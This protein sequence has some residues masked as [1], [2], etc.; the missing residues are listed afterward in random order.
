[1]Q[2][3]AAFT[4]ELTHDYQDQNLVW[5][6]DLGARHIYDVDAEGNWY[7]IGEFYDNI[8]F[9]N[10]TLVP[11]RAPDIFVAKL[12]HNGDWA[13][14]KA[15][16]GGNR[17]GGEARAL[18]VFDDGSVY[19]TGTFR[20]NITLGSIKLSTMS[21]SCSSC[22]SAEANAHDVFVAKLNENGEW[23]WATSGGGTAT[24]QPYAM[25]LTSQGEAVI[26]GQT[27]AGH[28]WNVTFGD[29]VLTNND[30]ESFVAKLSSDGD[31]LWANQYGICEGY[32][33]SDTLH[34]SKDGAIYIA[35]DPSRHRDSGGQPIF[36]EL[37]AEPHTNGSKTYITMV[38]P[39]GSFVWL[40]SF[41]TNHTSSTTA[42]FVILDIA[43]N[44]QGDVYFGG[45]W[46]AG[47]DRVETD[48][49]L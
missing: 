34:V 6:Y 11:L 31:W 2:T 49:E 18:Q 22:N 21:E 1:M 15:I 9:G 13:W 16:V 27:Q 20:S 12:N 28:H 40:K 4:G 45:V 23:L 33:T 38:A 29:T 42:K 25:E 7:F 30:T 17:Y 47:R 37:Y 35:P 24:D 10:T 8:T 41:N 39:N 36:G 5:S 14:A 3:M 46:N 43:T 44:V 26:L 19:I 48:D 32:C